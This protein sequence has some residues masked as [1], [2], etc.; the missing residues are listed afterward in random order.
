MSVSHAYILERKLGT[1]AI[2]LSGGVVFRFNDF[3]ACSPH[4]P[5]RTGTDADRLGS[6]CSRQHSLGQLSD[7][8]LRYFGDSVPVRVMK[9]KAGSQ[10]PLACIKHPTYTNMPDNVIKTVDIS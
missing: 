5:F 1:Q 8:R 2:K 9:L 7:C 4:D 3:R 10:G 6:L